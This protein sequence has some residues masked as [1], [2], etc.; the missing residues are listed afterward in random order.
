MPK[1]AHAEVIPMKIKSGAIA[2]V[3]VSLLLAISIT[4]SN[5]AQNQSP[6]NFAQPRR[7]FK[8][9]YEQSMRKHGI[10]GSGFMLIQ[11]RDVIAQEFFGLADIEK[12][13][14]VDE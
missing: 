1:S 6:R 7:E 8:T 10:V 11:D 4:P 2:R 13:D 12:Q 5:M 3:L 14:P 9:F